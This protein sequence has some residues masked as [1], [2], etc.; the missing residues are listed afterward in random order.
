LVLALFFFAG[1]LTSLKRSF[2]VT[3]FVKDQK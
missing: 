2:S 3:V 1:V